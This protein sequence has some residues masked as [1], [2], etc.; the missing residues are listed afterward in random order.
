MRRAA[1]AAAA[2]LVIALPLTALSGNSNS[3][4]HSGLLHKI[5]T[6]KYSY[7]LIECVQISY[8]VTNTT[9]DPIEVGRAYSCSPLW[10][11]AYDPSPELIWSDPAGCVHEAWWDTLDPG[12][13]YV[14]ESSWDMYDL[15][16]ER[17]F[18]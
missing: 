18:R 11:Y 3:A 9:E 14:R 17:L 2:A 8:V 12:E 6:D 15:L 1:G 10:N 4:V 16:N 5:E 7:Q 13:P